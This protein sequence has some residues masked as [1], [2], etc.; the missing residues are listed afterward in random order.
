[1]ADEIGHEIEG[2]ANPFYNSKS[3][4]TNYHIRSIINQLNKLKMYNFEF[5]YDDMVDISNIKQKVID[6]NELEKQKKENDI[7]SFLNSIA[8]PIRI[9]NSNIITKLNTDIASIIESIKKI[10]QII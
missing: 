5:T 1:M 8:E 9:K 3:N 4:F 7:D 10:L 6:K 2:G